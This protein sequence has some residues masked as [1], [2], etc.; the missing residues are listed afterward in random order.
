MSMRYKPEHKKQARTAIVS[1]AGRRLRKDGYY[2]AGVDG[3]MADAG[4]TS[5]AFYTQFASKNDVLGEVLKDG[6]ARLENTLVGRAASGDQDWWKQFVADYLSGA[7]C[8]NVEEGCVMP[9]LSADVARA[10]ADTQLLYQRLLEGVVNTIT[11]ALPGDKD[12][13]AEERAW[14][15]LALLAGGVMLAR[16]LPDSGMGEGLLEACRKLAAR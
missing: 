8:R 5:G 2:G 1:A 13:S 10:G 3:I 9:A 11:P 16:T 12:M 7:H 15:T 14:A 4:M 6:F